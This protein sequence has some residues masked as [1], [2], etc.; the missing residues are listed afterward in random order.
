V[1]EGSCRR[2]FDGNALK[3]SKEGRDMVEGS[4][5]VVPRRKKLLFDEGRQDAADVFDRC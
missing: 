4:R 2:P 5:V 1:K 3:G